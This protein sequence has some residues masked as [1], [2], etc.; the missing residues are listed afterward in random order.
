MVSP[1]P[2]KPEP[3]QEFLAEREELLKHKW[4]MS[5]K[6]GEDVGFEVALSDWAHHHRAQWRQQ[7]NRALALTWAP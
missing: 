1:Q 5:E 2:L 6:A 7:R 4:L 3:Y